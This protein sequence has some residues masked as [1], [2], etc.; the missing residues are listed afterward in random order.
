[1]IKR[2]LFTIILT[3]FIFNNLIAQIQFQERVIDSTNDISIGV[4]NPFGDYQLRATFSGDFDGDGDDDLLTKAQPFRWLENTNGQGDFDNEHILDADLSSVS[5]I[6]IA[7]IDNDGDVDILTSE[8]NN[9]N[10][11]YNVFIV[12]YENTDG[13]GDFSIKHTISINGDGASRLET[14]DI[15]GDND[16]DLIAANYLDGEISWYENEDGLGTFGVKQA[17]TFASVGSTTHHL[18]IRAGDFDGDTDLDLIFGTRGSPDNACYLLKNNDGL[19]TFDSPQEI[20]DFG[21][22]PY[23]IKSTDLD[24]DGDLDLYTQG[25]YG[26]SAFLNDGFG[27]FSINSELFNTTDIFTGF[28][29]AFDIDNDDDQ[30]M[31][32]FVRFEDYSNEFRMIVFEN[33]DGL[34]TFSEEQIVRTGNFTKSGFRF[35]LGD[36]NADGY[37]DI[38]AF[39]LDGF[40]LSWNENLAGSGF[41]PSQQIRNDLKGVRSIISVDIDNDGDNDVVFGADDHLKVGLYNNTG[42]NGEFDS[43][44]ILSVNSYD[45]KIVNSGDL[46]G[47]GFLDVLVASYTDN[48]IE[49][50]RNDG[51][52]NFTPQ[53][54]IATDFDNSGDIMT[55]DID[56]DTDLDIIAL[57]IVTNKLVWYEN[58]DGQGNF[59][60][61]KLIVENI[62]DAYNFDVGDIDGDGNIDIIINEPLSW[63]VSDG[64]G[65]FGPSQGITSTNDGAV[66]LADLDNDTD[67]DV[68][69]SDPFGWYENEDGEDGFG[70]FQL[71]DEN[72]FSTDD[73]IVLDIDNDGDL[74]IVNTYLTGEES[75]TI[76]LYKNYSGVFTSGSTL[77][78][79]NQYISDLT[80]NDID[81]N[82]SVDILYSTKAA[83]DSGKIAWLMNLGELNN[84]VRGVVTYDDDSDGCD[85]NDILV[86]NILVAG[87][88]SGASF[89]TFTDE[90]GGFTLNVNQGEI[91]T[92]ITPSLPNYFSVDPQIHF[93]NFQGENEIDDTAN[94]CITPNATVNDLN[95]TIYPLSNP[96]PGFDMSYEIIYNNI[97]TT[98][99]S[100]NVSLLY[101]AAKMQYLNAS[102]VPSSQSAGTINFDF[103]NLAPF[104]NRSIT[105]SFNVFAPPTTNINDVISSTVSIS[106]IVG[107]NTEEDNIYILEQTVIG[108]YDPNDILVLEGE[109]ILLEQADDYL[110]YIIRFQ[111]TGTAEAINVNVTNIID[112][113]L[114]W[115]T[116]QLEGMSHEGQMIIE[117]GLLA[118]FSFEN[119]NLPSQNQNEQASNGYIAYKIKPKAGANIGD[120]FYNDAAIFFDFNPPIYTN[121]VS[122]EV[123][124]ALSIDDFDA[125]GVKIYPNPTSGLV[126]IQSNFTIK[127]ITISDINGRQIN[128]FEATN[129]F[130]LEDLSR[131]V[132]FAKI[133]VEDRIITKKI[134]RE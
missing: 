94:F 128:T 76:K 28:A 40:E 72:P 54:P 134:I 102:E 82:G 70:D 19:G 96:R 121:R 120:I 106:P 23:Y 6:N 25:T 36:F 108:A 89:T 12:W 60:T 48:K 100:G 75:E 45:V 32:A 55:I 88:N 71:L 51:L 119:I 42:N 58:L 43:Q 21:I 129:Q 97:G 52:G 125:N 4:S 65:N 13:L 92:L 86:P 77:L 101:D 131:G 10:D 50:L 74:D 104:E 103:S 16:L 24:N 133:Y 18:D 109:Q 39:Y 33:I 68:L 8:A 83:S 113:N 87:G 31:V 78:E 112:A 99:L 93:S 64:Q 59:G 66:L 130:S 85:Y 34:G 105:I 20:F 41:G 1:M 111:N 46:D 27:N 67:L 81:G 56:G 132:Y 115:F 53:T 62:D 14:A 98:T 107:D 15:D 11:N 122:T 37:K 84:Q 127:K 124:D 26:L 61:E 116:I 95:V 30:D 123:V 9:D 49:W 79:T 73:M 35:S 29:N 47:D 5:A 114:E 57:E 44:E 90:N 3:F 38:V 118:T 110:H 126:K 117:D 91:T 7:D 69:T 2:L 17:I 80:S 22:G 63:M